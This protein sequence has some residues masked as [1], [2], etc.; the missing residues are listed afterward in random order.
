MSSAKSPGLI[1]RVASLP[2]G[3]LDRFEA[4]LD[5]R[6]DAGF[7]RADALL[8]RRIKALK[9]SQ[10]GLVSGLASTFGAVDRTLEYRIP[11]AIASQSDSLWI[12]T[13]AQRVVSSSKRLETRI[14]AKLNQNLQTL[15]QAVSV[16]SNAVAV[17]LTVSARLIQA[18]ENQTQSGFTRFDE[19]LSRIIT[20]GASVVKGATSGAKATFHAFDTALDNS[21]AGFDAQILQSQNQVQLAAAASQNLVNAKAAAFERVVE[22][23]ISRIDSSIERQ[24]TS[25]RV[26][27]DAVADLIS[28]TD[29]D[30]SGRIAIADRSLDTAIAK[31]T[32]AYSRILGLAN[33]NLMRADSRLTTGL[34]A[35]DTGIDTAVT[36]LTS[37]A[38]EAASL[39]IRSVQLT[40][41]TLRRGLTNVDKRID[42][43]AGQSNSKASHAGKRPIRATAWAAGLAIVLGT[44]GT[45]TGTSVVTAEATPVEIDNSAQT[46]TIVAKAVVSQYMTVRES[47]AALQASRTRTI[48]TLESEI[49]Q[50][51]VRAQQTT[52][53]G[54]TVIQIASKYA[55][56]SYSR[57]GTTPSGFDC[58]GFTSH[59]FSQVGVTLPRTSGEQA[60]WADRI[61][62]SQRQVGDLMFWADRGGVHHV[63][64]Y[65]GDDLMWD[66]PRPGR[67]VGKSSIWGNPFYGRVPAAAVNSDAIAEIADKTAELEEI[68]AEVPQLEITVD[69]IPVD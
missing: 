9:N 45:A 66:S 60:A 64:I 67:R 50:T 35:A 41:A 34:N 59:V 27:N 17:P 42:D 63:A 12:T 4:R 48:L 36:A 47:F 24:T 68:K 16:C 2:K 29:Q 44:L 54:D 28:N 39:A 10:Q 51:Q 5:S 8:E 69:P 32:H 61:S 1:Q 55:G 22:L 13:A 49:A 25:V 23:G 62:E 56:V 11:Q 15:D 52:I 38:T 43:F 57:G 30:L 31:S 58:S 37:T 18:L 19:G 65:A 14:D 33:R 53:N 46:E 7:N 6:V 26:A 3:L 21:V 40:D 20:S